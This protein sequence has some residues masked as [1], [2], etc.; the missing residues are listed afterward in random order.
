MG[1][2]KE[3]DWPHWTQ[4]VTD[5]IEA[6]PFVGSFIATVVTM[7]VAFV[8]W[9]LF[10]TF[11]CFVWIPVQS[12]RGLFNPDIPAW[13]SLFGDTRSLRS[14]SRLDF[15][16]LLIVYGLHYGAAVYFLFFA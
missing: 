16:V 15:A 2:N 12:V 4:Q 3:Q 8:S 7:V 13:K 6:I 14:P 5:V 11:H 10:V 9:F 1:D